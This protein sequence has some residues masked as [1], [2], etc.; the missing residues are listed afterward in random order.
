MNIEALNKHA[1]YLDGGDLVAPFIMDQCSNCALGHAIMVMEGK[2]D[3]W[4]N[5]WGLQGAAM[6]IFGIANLS[7]E[8]DFLFDKDWPNDPHL[9]AERFR[10][11]ARHGAAPSKDQWKRFG[12]ILPIPVVQIEEPAGAV[13]C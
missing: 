2:T 5:A 9:A 13:L 8:A 7:L 12:C 1:D 4:N 11:V 10:Y 3:F 6:R